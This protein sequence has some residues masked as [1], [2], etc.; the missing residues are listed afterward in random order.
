MSSSSEQTCDSARPVA[1][2]IQMQ[3]TLSNATLLEMQRRIAWITI[4]TPFL[5]TIAAIGLLRVT[6]MSMATL[7]LLFAMHFVGM[8]GITT[9]YHRLFAHRSFKTGNVVKVLLIVM[10][11][12]AA[13]GPVIHWVSNHRRHHEFS[14]RPGDTHSPHI[15]QGERF[16]WIR[17]VW[18]AHIGWMFSSEVTNPARYAADLLR[19]PVVTRMNRLYPF[20]VLLGIAI[21]AVLGGILSASWMG[22]LNGG[23][24]GGL[25]RIFTVHHATW[26]INSIT[27]LYG[28]RPYVSREYSTN[29]V[30]LALPSAGEAWHN[31]HHAFPASA[32][33]GLAWWQIDLGYLLIVALQWCGLAWDINT[34]SES[35]KAAKLARI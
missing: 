27:H 32:R 11:S 8:L 24:W 7:G 31:C 26:S 19:D 6:D 3:P 5:G 4:I 33:F 28:K 35:A 9:G 25:V 22:A 14:D 17:G 13:E 30:W 34:P 20:W 16:G 15:Y 18:H 10:G 2:A 23:L 29:N 1:S 21:P 12:M